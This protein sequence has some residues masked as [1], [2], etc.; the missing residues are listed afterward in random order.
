MLERTL[1]VLEYPKI[2]AKLAEFASSTRGKELVQELQP[3][4]YLSEIREA[5][6]ITSEAVQILLET[7]RIPLGGIFDIRNSLR[8]AA[9]GGSLIPQ[10][11]LEIAATIRASRLMREFLSEQGETLTILPEWG[12]RLAA[13]P[14]L[15]RE[16]E[17]CI[18]DNGEVND[19]ASP[20]LHSLRSQIKVFQN[21]V[22]DKLDSI[23]RSSENGKYLQDPIV[24]VRNERYVIPVKQE[25]RSFFPGIVHDQS[26]S[27]ATL[28]IE[29]MSVV[30]L[31]N[32]LRVVESQEVEEV[33]RILTELSGRVKE[34]QQPLTN[35]VAILARLDLAFAKGRYSLALNASEPQ[36]NQDGIIQLYDAR[37][38]ML[39]GKV[40][41]ITALLGQDYDTLVITGPNTGGKTVT[42][43][44]VGLLT[45][46][47][48][49]GLHIPAAPGSQLAVFNQVFCDIGDEQSIEQSL[50]TFSSHLTQIVKIIAA[51]QGPDS[52]VLLDE[53]GAGTDPTE[54]AALAMSILSHLHRLGVRTV[55]TTHYSELKV[56]AYKTPGLRNA[57]VEFDIATLRP[58]YHLTIGLPGSSQAFEIAAKLG[59]P[60]GIV[61]EARGYISAEEAKV[62]QILRQIEADSKQAREDRIAGEAARVKGET[63]KQQYEAELKRLQQERAELLRQAKAEA[64]E[65]L[66]EARRDSENLLRRLKEAPREELSGIVNEAR[67]RITKELERLD[68]VKTPARTDR[69]PEADDLKPGGKVRAISLNQVGTVLEVGEGTALVQLGIMKVNLPLGDIEIIAEPKVKVQQPATKRKSGETGLDAAKTISAEVNLRGMTVDEALYEL[70]KYLDQALLAGLERFRIIHG[71]GTGALRIGV[72]QFLKGHPVVR[73]FSF[74]EQSEGGLGATVVELKR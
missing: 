13:F 34:V 65:I 17:R 70:E 14:G 53:L 31:N 54:G 27:G 16:I 37:H 73:S 61:N 39:T 62:E 10:E 67:Q 25:Y 29:P 46:M 23:V 45:L 2:I 50:S 68:E 33:E 32:Q 51:A 26:A 28:F 38:P 47:A 21:R 1:T 56:F 19:S 15:E 3:L 52:L 41:P 58:T 7:D 60:M 64:R 9:L 74:A 8:K 11:L 72:Q 49:S 59:L 36:L 20:K 6:Q 5:Q 35:A 22:R 43:K 30:E 48:Q 40:V 18:A 42:L 69:Q 44:T 4:T 71:K 63:Y 12:G 66:I 24:T 57:A 55:A